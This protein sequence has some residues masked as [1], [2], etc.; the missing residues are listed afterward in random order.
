MVFR[1]L[2]KNKVNWRNSRIPENTYQEICDSW[3]ANS[4]NSNVSMYNIKKIR[5]RNFLEHF[6]NTADENLIQETKEMKN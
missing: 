3:L 6:K 5:K 2:D 4:I 1:L